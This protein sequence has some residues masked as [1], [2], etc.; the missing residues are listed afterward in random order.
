MLFLLGVLFVSPRY[1]FWFRMTVSRFRYSLVNTARI[2]V[3]I[4]TV[5]PRTAILMCRGLAGGFINAFIYL[6]L[7]LSSTRNRLKVLAFITVQ[8]MFGRCTLK[9]TAMCP[10]PCSISRGFRNN[11]V[12]CRDVILCSRRLGHVRVSSARIGTD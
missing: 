10:C 12:V 6:L 8:T 11:R 3:L 1:G 7:D 2:L 4:H 5:T 9:G